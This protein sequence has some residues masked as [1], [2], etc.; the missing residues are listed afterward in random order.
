M[1]YKRGGDVE[2]N[3]IKF[4]VNAGTGEMMKRKLWENERGDFYFEAGDA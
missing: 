2:Q 3:K 1:I 4:R